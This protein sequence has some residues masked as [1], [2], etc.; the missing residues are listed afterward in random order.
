MHCDIHLDFYCKETKN[1]FKNLTYF[2][3]ESRKASNSAAILQQRACLL[4]DEEHSV[5]LR[6][7][8]GKKK[9]IQRNVIPGC[10]FWQKKYMT[11]ELKSD[12]IVKKKKFLL[13]VNTSCE[14]GMDTRV[15]LFFLL[16]NLSEFKSLGCYL[17][18]FGWLRLQYSQ[19]QN[20]HKNIPQV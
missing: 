8:S 10:R 11:L 4:W 5:T 14:N 15:V 1:W 2:F 9:I 19:D 6:W 3:P 17:V 20:D 18:C 12:M 7:P 13:H 16:W